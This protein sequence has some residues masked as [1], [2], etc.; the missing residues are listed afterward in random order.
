[1]IV[2]LL[3]TS[4]IVDSREVFQVTALSLSKNLIKGAGGWII[5]GLLA[6][7]KL[8]GSRLDLIMPWLK[9]NSCYPISIFP[10]KDNAISL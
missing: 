1:M 7:S 10:N 5:K 3:F 4:V 8:H 9:S 6:S 2:R